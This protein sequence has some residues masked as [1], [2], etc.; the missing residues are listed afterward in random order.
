VEFY[1]DDQDQ[2][3]EESIRAYPGAGFPDSDE[4]LFQPHNFGIWPPLRLTRGSSVFTI[5]SCFARNIEEALSA[6]GFDVPLL[7]FAVPPEEWAGRPNGILNRYTPQ[8]IVQVLEWAVACLRNPERAL[9]ESDRY[10]IET[11]PGAGI[12]LDLLG[13]VTVTRDR[14]LDR[15]ADMLAVYSFL[16]SADVV[17]ITLGQ[18]EAWYY[19][20]RQAYWGATP[21]LAS[22]RW[23]WSECRYSRV[24]A[25]EAFRLTARA[26]DLIRQVNAGCTILLTV[27]PVPAARYWTG[28]PA[29]TAY[30]DTK[31]ALRDAALRAVREIPDTHYFPAFEAIRILPDAFIPDRIHVKDEAVRGVISALIS[32]NCDAG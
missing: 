30:W 9:E 11:E 31:L 15:R 4:R 7:R 32:A 21:A 6:E 13:Q 19:G 28:R 26:I 8:G 17:V 24:D 10:W 20:P 1:N 16:A 27:S 2:T 12:D 22:L 18:V 29:L 25:D 5:G 3:L 23:L 14:F